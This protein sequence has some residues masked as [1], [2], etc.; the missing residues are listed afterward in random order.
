[1]HINIGV[2]IYVCVEII[3]KKKQDTCIYISRNIDQC[4]IY[5]KHTCINIW[6]EI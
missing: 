1:M 3:L 5:P 6:V 2:I 4:R